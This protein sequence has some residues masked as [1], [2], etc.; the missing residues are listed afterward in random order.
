MDRRPGS[1]RGL[2]SRSLVAV[3]VFAAGVVPGWTLGDLIE[4]WTGNALLDWLM[5]CAWAAAAVAALAPHTSYR[6]RDAWLGLVP[7]AGWYLIALMA[8]RVALLPYR[9][10]EPRADEMWRARWLTGEMVGYW[11]TD[12]APA[13]RQRRKVRAPG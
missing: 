8:W 10:W 11:R 2:T 9:D 1:P 3:A 7:L 12:L 13:P 6:R 5:T 4:R